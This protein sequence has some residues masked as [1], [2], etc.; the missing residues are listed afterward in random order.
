MASLPDPIRFAHLPTPIEPLERLSAHLAGTAG[1]G[2]R[3]FVKRDDCTGL[4][5]GGN[6]TRK[7]EYLL[8]DALARGAD[9]VITAGG[10]QSNHVRQTAAAAARL[11]LACTL[12]LSRSVPVADPDYEATGNIQL[13]RLLGATL[14]FCATSDERAPVMEQVAAEVTAEGGRP[15]VIPVG[16]SNPLG[17]LGYVACLRELAEQERVLGLSFDRLVLASSSAG[18]QAGLIAGCRS[19]GRGLRVTGIDVDADPEGLEATVRDLAG[20]TLALLES[21][22]GGS[23]LPVEIVGGHAGSAYGVPS[24]EG[25]EAIRLLA[26]LE[27][28]LL[29]PVYSG[30]AMAGLLSL[31]AKGELRAGE[32]VLFLHSGGAPALFAYRSWFEAEPGAV[33]SRIA[34]A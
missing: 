2:P 19:L 20:E 3:I 21:H 25:L 16:G 34:G 15:Y 30:K 4:A 28:L 18:T 7:L 33:A 17:A 27:G 26:R 12:V 23:A 5:F 24:P 8:A 13:D 14:R 11:G 9:H 31:A 6:K 10:V 32:T 22:A 29:D 1:R